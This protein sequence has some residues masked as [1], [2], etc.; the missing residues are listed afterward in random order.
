MIDGARHAARVEVC[1]LG[2]RPARARRVSRVERCGR[3]SLQHLRAPRHVVDRLPGAARSSRC[4]RRSAPQVAA[5]VSGAGYWIASDLG[6]V[7]TFG[8]AP[9]RRQRASGSRVRSSASPGNPSGTGYWLFAADGGVFSF[10]NAGFSRWDARVPARGADRRHGAT[11]TG[12]GYWLV[13]GD[14]GVFSFGDARFFGS[15]GALRLNAPVLGMTPTADRQGILAVRPRR[16]MFSFGDAAFHGSTG[17]IRLNQPVVSM[18]ARPQGDGYWM[19]APDG[20]VFAFGKAP[21]KG[22]GANSGR[23]SPCV[24]MLPDHDRQGLHHAARATVGRRRSATRPTSV[25]CPR[26][27]RPRDRHRGPAEDRSRCDVASGGGGRGVRASGGR[28]ARASRR[29][30]CCCRTPRARLRPSP[31]K[32][33]GAFAFSGPRQLRCEQPSGAAPVG[34]D[35]ETR[36][37]QVRD[38]RRCARPRE[39]HVERR[40]HDHDLVSFATVPGDA[41]RAR[42]RVIAV[43]VEHLAERAA[44]PRR[45]PRAYRPDEHAARTRSLTTSR[46]PRPRRQSARAATI[47]TPARATP[48]GAPDNEARN[49][50]SVSRRVSVP[51]KSN[52]ATVSVHGLHRE[53]P[54]HRG[55]RCRR[56]TSRSASPAVPRRLRGH[57]RCHARRRRRPASAPTES[58][59]A[60]MPAVIFVCTN[61]GPHDHHVHAAARERG[62]EALVVAVDAG[63]RRAVHEVR[64]PDTLA[65]DRRQQHQRAVTLRA[66]RAR[67]AE[68]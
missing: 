51:S 49:G 12:N 32:P 66:Q 36:A 26:H 60:F 7:L 53:A 31:R 52:A 15:T 3:G 42:R 20:G 57:G 30:R 39:V 34:V 33:A 35:V 14:G 50:R 44:R 48:F 43:R 21:F 65:R 23:S 5:R 54:E 24:G 64:A 9:A 18:A 22:S 19:I 38:A 25:T 45:R 27:V 11:P 41:R 47:V 29:R 46:S 40:R 62:R 13:A 2:D 6:Q 4:C 63:L 10:G 37:Q 56:P 67:R 28:P 61:P 17:D 55:G 8:G 59:A 1:A 68:Q 16:G 58:G